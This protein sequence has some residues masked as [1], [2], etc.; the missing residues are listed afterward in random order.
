M[1]RKTVRDAYPLPQTEEALYSLHDTRFYSTLDLAQGYY[2]VAMEPNDISKTAFRVGTGGLYEYLR[3]PMDLSNST[4][5]FQRVTEACFS[6]TIFEI[7][8]IYLDDILVFSKTVE[9]QIERLAFIFERLQKDGVKLKPSKC[10]FFLMR[11]NIFRSYNFRGR[12]QNQSRETQATF[13]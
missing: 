6:D 9:E 12:C 13:V 10:L 1:N 8:L 3:M 7:L 2:Q 11:S 4:A 5:T